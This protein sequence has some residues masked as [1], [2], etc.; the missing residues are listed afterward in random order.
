MLST[1]ALSTGVLKNPLQASSS[2]VKALFGEGSGSD[3]GRGDA[4]EW[5]PNET[6]FFGLCCCEEE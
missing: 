1:C 5:R 4:F 6:E 2:I 3:G